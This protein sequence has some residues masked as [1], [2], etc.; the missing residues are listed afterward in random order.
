MTEECK[1]DIFVTVPDYTSGY[2]YRVSQKGIS[3]QIIGLFFPLFANVA[4]KITPY[5]R[6]FSPLAESMVLT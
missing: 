2:H 6:M 5:T 4:R 1:E 3:S